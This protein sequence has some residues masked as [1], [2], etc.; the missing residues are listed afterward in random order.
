MR[1]PGTTSQEVEAAKLLPSSQLQ[2]VISAHWARYPRQQDDYFNSPYSVSSRKSN[3]AAIV[4]SLR[5]SGKL[6]EPVAKAAPKKE[7]V[8]LRFEDGETI[9]I[10]KKMYERMT[11][12]ELEGLTLVA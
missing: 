5:A 4:L 11:D 6:S 1:Y 2:K 9:R 10:S 8:T 7:R 3:A 12:E